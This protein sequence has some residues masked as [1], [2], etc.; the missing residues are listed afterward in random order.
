MVWDKSGNDMTPVLNYVLSI[1]EEIRRKN[2][3][4]CKNHKLQKV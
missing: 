3:V 4:W 1:I 2:D